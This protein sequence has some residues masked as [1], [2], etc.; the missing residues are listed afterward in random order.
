MAVY[1]LFMAVNGLYNENPERNILLNATVRLG[2]ASV[3]WL[4]VLCPTWGRP[5]LGSNSIRKSY[6]GHR[7]GKMHD[8]ERINFASCV[9]F[10]K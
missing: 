3:L 4:G 10:L 2:K 9:R 7:R 5:W 6:G 8:G 1:G